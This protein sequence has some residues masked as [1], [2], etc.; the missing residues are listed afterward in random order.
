MLKAFQNRP[1]EESR[2][3]VRGGYFAFVEASK[4]SS[5]GRIRPEDGPF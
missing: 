1:L 5:V 2:D 3:N 4:E